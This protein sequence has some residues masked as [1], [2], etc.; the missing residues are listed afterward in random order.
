MRG[1]LGGA[2][3]D[4]QEFQSYRRA[5]QPGASTEQTLDNVCE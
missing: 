2:F 1:H 3:V 4:K 5:Q